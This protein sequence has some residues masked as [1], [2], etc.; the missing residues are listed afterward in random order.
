MSTSVNAPDVGR[1]SVFDSVTRSILQFVYVIYYKV[2]YFTCIR[3]IDG[4]I[5]FLSV[6]IISSRHFWTALCKWKEW[7]SVMYCNIT[8]IK[9]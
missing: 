7:R 6:V 4:M 8:Q 1:E 2:H 3:R 9:T 5:R